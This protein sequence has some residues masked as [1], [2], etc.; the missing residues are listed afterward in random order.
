MKSNIRLIAID[1]D[2]TLLNAQQKVTSASRAAVQRVVQ[3]GIST[4]LVTGRDSTGAQM[5]LS[6]LGMDLPYIC[7]AGSLIRSGQD[8]T[9]ISARPFHDPEELNKVIAYVRLNLAGL[10]A[11]LPDGKMCWY[12][13]DGLMDG[14]DPLTAEVA[15]GSLRAF[16]PEQDFDRPILKMSIAGDLAFLGAIASDVLINLKAIHHVYAGLH[17]VDLTA[18]GVDRGSALEIF[19]KHANI[20]PPE[21][22]AIG[23]QPIDLPMFSFAGLSV[24]M[25]NAPEHIKK[26][27]DWTAP[28]ND[29]DGVAHALLKILEDNGL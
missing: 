1:L 7:S 22:A 10:V 14:L 17:Y 9:M 3:A 29:A 25:G 15:R 13:P 18:Q 23:D 26:L 27:A 2:G 28:S 19:A 21:I 8:G 6:M 16:S 20:S 4:I 11:D 24:A 5:V 12:G